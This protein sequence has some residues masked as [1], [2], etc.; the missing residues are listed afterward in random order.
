MGTLITG[1]PINV[2]STR[3]AYATTV[4]NLDP[5]EVGS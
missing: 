2:H 5:R 4:L 1:K 3:Y